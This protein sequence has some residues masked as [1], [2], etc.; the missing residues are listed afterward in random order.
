MTRKDTDTS[1]PAPAAAKKKSKPRAATAPGAD[2]QTKTANTTEASAPAGPAAKERIAKAM[3]RVGLCSRR[4]A[5]EWIA[6]GRVSVNGT[7]LTS[8][9]VTVG[10]DD[11][12]VVD[13][14][15][16]P[17]RE[18]TRLW[19]YHKPRGLITTTADPE[20]RDTVF[21]HLPDDLPRVVTVGRLDI[22]TEGLLLLTNDGGL[23]RVLELPAT[24]WLRRYRVRAFGQVDEAALA[25]LRDG[26]V[27]DGVEYGPIEAEIERQ[28]G[29]NVWLVIGL[30]EGKNREIKRVLG[31]LGLAVN[32]LIRVSFG[33]FQLAELAEGEVREIR[34]RVL[35]DQL[36]PRLVAE[37]GADFEAPFLTHVGPEEAD[38][39]ARQEAKAD[40]KGG[41]KAG[42]KGGKGERPERT[43]LEYAGTG[44]RTRTDRTRAAGDRSEGRPERP[45]RASGKPGL[46]S[47]GMR[48]QEGRG[49][50]AGFRDRPDAG[51]RP[52]GERPTGPRGDRPA[53]P[54]REGASERPMRGFDPVEKGPRPPRST[55]FRDRPEGDRPR[56]P[57]PDGDRPRSAGFRDRPEGDRPRSAGFRDRPDGDRPRGPRPGGFKD[58]PEGERP[59]GPRPD[60]DRPPRS[61]GFRDRPEGDRPRG[62]RPGGFR[63]RPEG[64]AP[65]KRRPRVFSETGEDL[66]EHRPSRDDA[67]RGRGPRDDG[68]RGARPP[69]TEGDRPP[70]REGGKPGGFGGKPGGFKPKGGP[71]GGGRPGGGR[72]GGK[73]GGF[74]GKPG[75]GGA[76]R[77]R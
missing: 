77:R 33:P 75:G 6:A 38:K 5:E 54:P 50:A 44:E 31:S 17:T 49:R 20:G 4:E 28:Q 13:G 76:D 57:R 16:L 9:A 27:V 65:V 8:P 47:E 42:A 67:P 63:D 55:G 30:R 7:V 52:R 12:V 37:A 21:D 36:G 39:R 43:K 64:G 46:R 25:K 18:R 66:G 70:R 58:R 41:A 23:A 34:G 22:N 11:R 24:G 48:S 45:A 51:D 59:R 72:P 19:L 14:V 26:L 1:S 56:G 15:A 40:R 69:R 61:G 32:R 68:A 10:P 73:P 3:A 53:R 2:A 60:G 74:G 29:S 62:P 71:G 35:K